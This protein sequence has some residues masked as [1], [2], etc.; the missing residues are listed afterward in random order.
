M[1]F[2]SL[3]AIAAIA[4]SAHGATWTNPAWPGDCADPTFWQA[5]DGTWRCSSTAK[6]ILRSNDF[7]HWENTGKHL[8]TEEE[9]A[10]IRKEWAHIWA[11]DMFK[12]GDEYLL[13][14][15]LVNRLEDSA[16]A[17]YSSKDP[18][19]PFMDGHILTKGRDTGIYDTIDP[20][21]VR[22]DKTGDLWLF[23]GSVGK[24]HRV[25][26][27]P[28]GKSLAP[29]AVYEHM[30]GV[31]RERDNNPSRSKVFEGT[32]LHRRGG[33]WYLFASRGR[34]TDH[35]YAVVVGRARTLAGP[36]LDREGRAMKDGFA[37]TV[38]SSKEGDLFFGPG[39]NG[40][41]VT[42]DGHDYLPYHCHIQNNTPRQR[43]L[44]IQELF[45]DDDGWPYVGNNGKPQ[46][47]CRTLQP[48]RATWGAPVDLGPGG[49]ARIRRLE[50]GRY[51]AAYALGGNMTIRFSKDTRTWTPPQV[52][53]QRFEAGSGTNR[54]FV[55]LA[56]AEFAQ[57]P[58]GRIVLACNLRPAGRR[59]DV[60]PLSIGFVTSDD[61]GASWSKLRVIYR[62]ET[63]SDG[64]VRGCWEPFVLPG[65]GGHVQIYFADETPYVDGRRLYQNISVIES[66]DEGK[67]WGPVRAASYNPRCRDGMPV[68]L[69]MGGWRWLAIET[70]GKG[71]HLH[72]EIVRSRVADNWSATVGSPSPDRF[73]P[74]LAPCDWRKSYGGAPYI[75]ATK[76]HVLLSWQETTQF[77]DDVLRTSAV[78]VAA[79]PKD[80]ITDGRFTT[81][82]F[83]PSPPTFKGAKDSTL[84]NSICP[85]DGDSFLLV[86]QYR[87]RIIVHPC[88]IND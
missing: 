33:W 56:N 71:T 72:P 77:E 29:G 6:S 85:L 62:S 17:V 10:R 44:F 24:V 9:Y 21:A 64:V 41:I 23:F 70:N 76:N 47:D 53:A 43:P 65:E 34:Y 25:K 73:S 31:H 54:L 32:Y 22:D 19:G 87:N 27:A 18:E 86:S 16:I 69:Q 88:R 2:I 55:N 79:V 58:S 75:A 83:L 60:H 82:R 11:P 84:W 40:E 39:H 52:A 66:P 81:M 1:K 30:A 20:E 46:R 59:A 51:M 26:L 5:P 45:W 49:Y 48:V 68:V 78:R 37:T 50:D 14:V 61:A 67:T 12:L 74:F 36:F 3:P 38:V 57:L 13:F 80:E 42:I 7:F 28:D 15:S 8:F 63:L 4:L 35:S